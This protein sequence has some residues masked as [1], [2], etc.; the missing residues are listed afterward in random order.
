MLHW[1]LMGRVFHSVSMNYSKWPRSNEIDGEEICS[2]FISNGL[3]LLSYGV[4]WAGWGYFQV[5]SGFPKFRNA[6]LF[7][8]STKMNQFSTKFGTFLMQL[9][10]GCQLTSVDDLAGAV[11]HMLRIIEQEAALCWSSH[12]LSKRPIDLGQN[13][14]NATHFSLLQRSF[15][16]SFF[17]LSKCF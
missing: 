13:H 2:H 17:G 14:H 16:S 4:E 1:S 8:C 3:Q 6:C 15:W 7:A 11:H 10:E 9:E 12:H 5:F